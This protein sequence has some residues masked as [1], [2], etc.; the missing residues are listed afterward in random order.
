ML[1]HRKI[2]SAVPGR[3]ETL[4][5]SSTQ[6]AVIQADAHGLEMASVGRAALTVVLFAG[7]TALAG[8]LRV[9]LPFTPVPLT[10]Q[11]IPVLLAGAV[12]GPGGG[13]CSQALLLI[14]GALGMPVFAAGGAGLAH[15]TGPTGGY[16]VGFPAAALL[17][18][19]LLRAR[20]APSFGRVLLAMAAGAVVIHAAGVVHLSIYTGGSLERALALGSLPFIPGDGLKLL[21][22]SAIAVGWRRLRESAE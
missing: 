16:L 17:V 10:L 19:T 4:P 11:V 13:A 20:R 15:L 2:S 21:A 18:G 5:A 7:L 3:A 6:A 1:N 8:Q 14:A 9:P 22:A 12:I